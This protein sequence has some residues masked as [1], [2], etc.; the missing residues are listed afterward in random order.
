MYNCVV[1]S[2]GGMTLYNFSSVFLIL[3]VEYIGTNVYYTSYIMQKMKMNITI[4]I[5][6]TCNCN[7]SVACNQYQCTY[8]KNCSHYFEKSRVKQK[9]NEKMKNYNIQILCCMKHKKKIVFLY[10]PSKHLFSALPFF[11]LILL[12]FL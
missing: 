2:K 11:F 6:V 1:H 3:N 5:M 7:S 4:T 8:I 9:K 10:Q 12:S